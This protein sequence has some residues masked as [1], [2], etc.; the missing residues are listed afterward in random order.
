LSKA[1]AQPQRDDRSG[2]HDLAIK[3]MGERFPFAHTHDRHLKLFR[4]DKAL[5]VEFFG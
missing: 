1:R 2:N 5:I 4:K 3:C